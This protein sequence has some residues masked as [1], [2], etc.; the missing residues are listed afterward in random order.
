MKNAQY[1]TQDVKRTCENKLDISFKKSRSKEFNG[2]FCLEGKKKYRI[3][4]PKGKKAIGQ[5]TYQ[6]MARQLGLSVLQFDDLLD[7]PIRLR[8]YLQIISSQML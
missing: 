4:V 3:T 7:C 2:W 6:S 1:N 5:K 8:E